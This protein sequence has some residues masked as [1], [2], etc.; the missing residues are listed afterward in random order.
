MVRAGTAAALP[1]L[2]YAPISGVLPRVFPVMSTE[3]AS[4]ARPAFMAAL[5]AS[6]CRL[7]FCAVL[8]QAGLTA[9]SIGLACELVAPPRW[10]PSNCAKLR[11]VEALCA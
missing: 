3:G 9:A 4:A 7:K 5:P 10:V 8:Y 1:L 6:N 11:V 2:W